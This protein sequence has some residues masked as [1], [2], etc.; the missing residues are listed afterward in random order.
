V[1]A[2]SGAVSTID[3]TYHTAVAGGS[4]VGGVRCIGGQLAESQASCRRKACTLGVCC[5]ECF[6]SI[7]DCGN[8]K[9]ANCPAGEPVAGVPVAFGK[10][11]R[12]GGAR[13]PCRCCAECGVDDPC[14]CTPRYAWELEELQWVMLHCTCCPLQCW[15]EGPYP[16]GPGWVLNRYLDCPDGTHGVSYECFA[17]WQDECGNPLP[18]VPPRPDGGPSGGGSGKLREDCIAWCLAASVCIANADTFLTMCVAGCRYFPGPRRDCIKD[19][20]EAYEIM[21]DACT[22]L[23][24]NCALCWYW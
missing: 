2:Q 15:I 11:C 16:Q 5:S 19:C 10:S 17:C 9:L 3:I 6:S 1:S 8:Y 21:M 12:A 24:V 20:Y 18:S 13:P 7:Q 14:A 23:I 22:P 4:G